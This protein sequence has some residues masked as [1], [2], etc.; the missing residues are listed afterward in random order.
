MIAGARSHRRRPP[1]IELLRIFWPIVA[2]ALVAQ[3][4]FGAILYCVV[5]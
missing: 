3:A 5:G 1:M 4:A 2:F